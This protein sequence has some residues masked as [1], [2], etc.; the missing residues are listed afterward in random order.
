MKAHLVATVAKQRCRLVA[1]CARGAR[2]RCAGARAARWARARTELRKGGE[3]GVHLALQ[4][5]RL[6][7]GSAS[8]GEHATRR[9][10]E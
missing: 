1:S 8:G 7:A 6:R 2:F 5:A 3:L 10:R 4:L 9:L